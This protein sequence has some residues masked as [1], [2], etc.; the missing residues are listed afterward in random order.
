MPV[1]LA[2]KPEPVTLTEVPEAPLVP[3]RE[4]LAAM[5][6]TTSDTLAA[7]VVAPEASNVWEPEVEAGMMKVAFQAPWGLAEMPEATVVVPS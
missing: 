5:V 1:S 4:M 6:K 3:L 7:D 2:A